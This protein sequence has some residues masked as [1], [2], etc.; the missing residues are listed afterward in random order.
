MAASRD[1]APS[2]RYRGS[3]HHRHPPGR[4]RRR[5]LVQPKW[6]PEPRL[7]LRRLAETVHLSDIGAG[8]EIGIPAHDLRPR[9]RIGGKYSHQ[10]RRRSGSERYG[11]ARYHRSDETRQPARRPDG[12]MG[13]LRAALFCGSP[14]SGE[15]RSGGYQ[16]QPD[17][18]PRS[19]NVFQDDRHSG[20]RHKSRASARE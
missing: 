9:R 12:S 8:G 7:S 18:F 15:I 14:A 17:R 5:C 16:S 6:S 4:P 3:A 19:G 2:E 20:L 1:H 13:R 10:A 11:A